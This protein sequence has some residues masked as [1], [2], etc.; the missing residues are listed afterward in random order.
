M[1][2][3]VVGRSTGRKDEPTKVTGEAEYAVG[4]ALPGMLFGKS[5]RSPHPSARIVRIDTPKAESVPGVRAVLTGA[6]LQGH[7]YGSPARDVPLLAVDIVRFA[8]EEVAVVAADTEELAERGAAG[9]ECGY[10]PR[11]GAL[12]I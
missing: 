10:A 8:G 5:V 9:P 4:V 12:W 2:Y 11:G 1:N 3:Q 7:R 6:D